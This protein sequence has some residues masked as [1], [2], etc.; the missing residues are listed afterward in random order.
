MI[1]YIYI[2]YARERCSVSSFLRRRYMARK[3]EMKRK[4]ST[5][6][7]PLFVFFWWVVC[8]V[9]RRAFLSEGIGRMGD[10]DA[11]RAKYVA[12]HHTIHICIHMHKNASER[13]K[14][15][16]KLKRGMDHHCASMPVGGSSASG[17][18][19]KRVWWVGGV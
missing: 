15:H 4:V 5:Q 14:A 6:R 17:L 3:P 9:L 1:I 8:V 19:M 11:V 13:N 16:L 18:L 2:A 10:G 12:R 7:V